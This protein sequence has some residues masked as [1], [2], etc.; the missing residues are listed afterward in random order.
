MQI[1][2]LLRSIGLTE[3]EIEIYLTC[4]KIGSQVASIISLR[5]NINRGTTYS[6]LKTLIKKG[7]I[8]QSKKAQGTYFQALDPESIIKYIDKKKENLDKK[9]D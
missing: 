8:T 4:L 5:S 6:V 7:L 3:N 1:E 2:S 9:K